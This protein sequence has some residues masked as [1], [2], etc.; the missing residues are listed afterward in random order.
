K[1]TDRRIN[2]TA[3]S[4]R[5][6][7]CAVSRPIGESLRPSDVDSAIGRSTRPTTRGS[8]TS[9]MATRTTTTRTTTTEPAPSAD[10]TAAFSF[11]ELVLAYLDCRRT[12]RNS[13]SALAFEAALE[14][15]LCQLRDELASG[16]YRPGRSI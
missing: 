10:S 14:S 4:C 6:W 16:E 9:A 7:P 5:A 2:G 11:E 12:K 1:A 13:A 3:G 15:N 8:R